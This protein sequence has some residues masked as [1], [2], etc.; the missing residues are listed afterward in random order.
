[1]ARCKACNGILGV[2]C[3]NEKDCLEISAYH[4]RQ[5]MPDAENYISLLI[6]TLEQNN[7]PVPERVG[8]LAPWKCPEDLGF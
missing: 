6:Q 3:Y 2:D 1:M 5:P 7:I 8:S 4:S